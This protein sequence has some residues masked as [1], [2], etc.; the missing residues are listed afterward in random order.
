VFF[1]ETRGAIYGP[2]DGWLTGIDKTVACDRFEAGRVG[3]LAELR[4]A[5]ESINARYR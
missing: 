2:Q 4:D 5:V 3:M 1:N